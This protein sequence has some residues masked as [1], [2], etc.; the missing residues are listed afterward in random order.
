GDTIFSNLKLAIPGLSAAVF[1][2]AAFLAG[3]AAIV[4]SG[5]RSIL[6][7]VATAIGLVVLLWVGAEA[8]FPH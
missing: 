3:L 4:R 2:I 5:D 8:V 6:V 1:G 7:F